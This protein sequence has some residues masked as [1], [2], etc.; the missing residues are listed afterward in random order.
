M[1]EH[2]GDFAHEAE[3]ILALRARVASL[4]HFERLCEQMQ[5]RHAP[6]VARVAELEIA[7][8]MLSRKLE[9]ED[10]DT[11]DLLDATEK[12]VRALGPMA[13]VSEDPP[14]RHCQRC[15][16]EVEDDGGAIVFC[17]LSCE[18]AFER[19]TSGKQLGAVGRQ[20]SLSA[21]ANP[22][23]ARGPEEAGTFNVDVDPADPS[24]RGTADQ[25][26]QRA[27]DAPK[28]Y[29]GWNPVAV[30]RSWLLT[31]VE[32]AETLDEAKAWA[33]RAIDKEDCPEDPLPN[34][35]S[36]KEKE[37]RDQNGIKRPFAPEARVYP[38]AS[39]QVA[40]GVHEVSL[41]EVESLRQQR[42]PEPLP[43][44]HCGVLGC[45]GIC[46]HRG[47]WTAEPTLEDF[48]DAAEHELARRAVART[49]QA[50]LDNREVWTPDGEPN[51]ACR[52]V[53]MRTAEGP[54][55]VMGNDPRTTKAAPTVR[56]WRCKHEVPEESTVCN[57]GIGT[58]CKDAKACRG[59][60]YMAPEQRPESDVVI[61]ALA[62]LLDAAYLD[63]AP[64]EA[65][66]ETWKESVCE[67]RLVHDSLMAEVREHRRRCT[68]YALPVARPV[69]LRCP[70]CGEM[71]TS[72]VIRTRHATGL[73][74]EAMHGPEFQAAQW[75]ETPV[76]QP[77]KKDQGHE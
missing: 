1:S 18:R 49:G 59:R 20:P 15:G 56:C 46:A 4:E 24:I 5:A 44:E 54:G 52:G 66:R 63:E 75:A 68:D 45:S 65:Q 76:V 69:D 7:L 23:P 31:I 53:Q 71:M 37:W 8:R 27:S 51:I 41:A 57:A 67:A 16:D 42:T 28:P 11:D 12:A 26:W 40:P 29:G 55:G 50:A 25:A 13:S 48:G 32:D 73:C 36:L 9:N 22:T 34:D 72:H 62:R 61:S 19:Q 10:L 60:W 77:A 47:G 58:Q 2:D 3:E 39:E 17:S 64:T 35:A 21:T 30:L 6:L 33:R 70:E 74:E 38:I 14:K 43:R